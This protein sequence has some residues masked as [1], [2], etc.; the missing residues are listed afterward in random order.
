[1]RKRNKSVRVRLDE[2]E[3][4]NL[5]TMVRKSGLTIQAYILS[6]IYD[7][8]VIERP[9]MDFT[10]TLKLMQNISNN[11]NQIA[12]KANTLGF[13]DTIAYWQNVHELQRTIGQMVET[14]YG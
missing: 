2:D 1:M 14:M 7:K 9:P 10:Q 6:L 8:P 5:M 12:V 3:Y 13:V 11:M 4:K